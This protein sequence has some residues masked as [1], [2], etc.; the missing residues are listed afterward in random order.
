VEKSI[1]T[2]EG[3]RG[4][5][6]RRVRSAAVSL[7]HPGE[8]RLPGGVAEWVEVRY[9]PRAIRAFGLEF[10]WLVWFLAI[11]MTSALVLKRTWGVAV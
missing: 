3:L 8:P 2:G 7:L 10:S 11:S 6:L 5:S 1:S 9:P 4:L